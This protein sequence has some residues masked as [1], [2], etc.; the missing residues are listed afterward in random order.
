MLSLVLSQDI[1]NFSLFLLEVL[2]LVPSYHSS[3]FFLMAVD[4]PFLCFTSTSSISFLYPLI[5]PE[6]FCCSVP[7][8]D[9]CS[10]IIPCSHL[11]VW[12]FRQQNPLLI[13]FKRCLQTLLAISCIGLLSML[14]HFSDLYSIWPVNG[15]KHKYRS[16]NFH[17]CLLVHFA[18]SLFFRIS[19]CCS[20]LPP[21]KNWELNV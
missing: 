16:E 15:V 14:F 5:S 2:S 11:S 8:C 9:F 12:L 4:A 10:L 7:H 1:L 6:H 20:W 18:V 21:L 19:L 3:A 13:S 17:T